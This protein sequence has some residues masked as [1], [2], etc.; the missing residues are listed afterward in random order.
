MDYSKG[1][2]VTFTTIRLQLEHPD[3]DAHRSRNPK[4]AANAPTG[5][6][7]S[8]QS[9]SSIFLFITASNDGYDAFIA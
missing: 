4:T 6:L 2:A 1:I 3:E 7:F 9:G 5:S 8:F